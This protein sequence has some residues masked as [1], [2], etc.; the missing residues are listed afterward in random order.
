M[1][2]MKKKPPGKAELHNFV[3]Q[4]EDKYKENIMSMSMKMMSHPAYGQPYV[5][6]L[7]NKL[8]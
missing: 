5:S 6:H 1:I 8:L 7:I 2:K 3:E 4:V